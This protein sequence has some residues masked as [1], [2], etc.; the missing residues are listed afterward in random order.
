MGS[1]RAGARAV[2]RAMMSR[3][4]LDWSCCLETMDSSSRKVPRPS[5]LSRWMRVWLRMKISRVLR[6]M[7]QTGRGAD[8]AFGGLF[9][10]V[11]FEGGDLGLGA[12]GAL[13]VDE[14]DGLAEL[15]ATFEAA[16]G[17]AVVGVYLLDLGDPRGVERATDGPCKDGVAKFG[18]ELEVVHKK[19]LGNGQ[20]GMGSGEG[21]GERHQAS[22]IGHWGREE[23]EETPLG[24][25]GSQEKRW[26]IGVGVR[27]V[28]AERRGWRV[29]AGVGLRS[30]L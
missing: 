23:G 24:E 21:S 26:L 4:H 15:L 20:W 6:T 18:F 11:D 25:W 10:R 12:V 8:E 27:V 22:G 29:L 5:T 7:V 13:V 30:R 17:D 19:A 28:W 1:P 14:L 9:L 2:R 16:R 3:A